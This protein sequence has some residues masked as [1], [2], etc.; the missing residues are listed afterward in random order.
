M[1]STVLYA[2]LAVA[3]LSVSAQSVYRVEINADGATVEHHGFAAPDANLA[4]GFTATYHLPKTV[5]GTYATLDYGRFV[6]DFRAR[7]SR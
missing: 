3:S 7:P 1:K 4:D 2:A 5:P 6:T